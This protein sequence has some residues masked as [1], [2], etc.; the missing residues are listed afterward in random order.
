[1]CWGR[2]SPSRPNG[3]YVHN[4]ACAI[5]VPKVRCG[6][7]A[8]VCDRP[9]DGPAPASTKARIAAHYIG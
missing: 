3:S 7:E 1:M 8:D 4:R 6:R 2:V 9:L 5:E